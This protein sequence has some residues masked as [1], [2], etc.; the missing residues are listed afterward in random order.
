M[1]LIIFSKINLFFANKYSSSILITEPMHI[2]I[3]DLFIKIILRWYYIN[4]LTDSFAIAG[5]MISTLDSSI[6]RL[7]S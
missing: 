1:N 5:Y 4:S 6:D 3:L 2:V 7:R